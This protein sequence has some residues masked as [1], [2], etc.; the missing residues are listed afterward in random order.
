[1]AS[2]KNRIGSDGMPEEGGGFFQNDRGD[3]A[4]GRNQMVARVERE[5][6][7]DRDGLIRWK[8]ADREKSGRVPC[9]TAQG[10][11]ANPAPSFP[12]RGL[13]ERCA[14]QDQLTKGLGVKKSEKLRGGIGVTVPIEFVEPSADFLDRRRIKPG[15]GQHL[16]ERICIGPHGDAS[17]QRG[18]ERCRATT[19]ERIVNDFP[20]AGE[21][22]DEKAGKLGF[23]ACAIRDFMQ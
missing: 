17:A 10:D 21:S 8:C 23:E 6:G 3:I 4:R 5:L 19:H 7:G 1:M 22:I 14:E 2:R 15:R 11:H 13:Y 20:S 18:F 12:E 16:A 9:E